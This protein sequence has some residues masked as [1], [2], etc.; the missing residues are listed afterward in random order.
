MNHSPMLQ[1]CHWMLMFERGPAGALSP[2][3]ECSYRQQDVAFSMI[4]A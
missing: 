1:P 2:D 4:A 3:G